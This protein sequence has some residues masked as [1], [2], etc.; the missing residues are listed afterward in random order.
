MKT[1]EQYL[2][3]LNINLEKALRGEYDAE[4]PTIKDKRE[5]LKSHRP[6]LD[7]MVDIFDEEKVIA[8][9]RIIIAR[10]KLEVSENE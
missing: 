1:Y 3:L 5:Y 4:H 6:N 9:Y 8:E 7:F 10:E 2:K